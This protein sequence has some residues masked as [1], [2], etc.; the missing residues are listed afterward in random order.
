V[1]IISSEQYTKISYMDYGNQP[2]F[3]NRDVDEQGKVI[4]IDAFPPNKDQIKRRWKRKGKLKRRDKDAEEFP[5]AS[6]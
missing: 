6:I 2:G 5:K 1:K 4:F 3:I